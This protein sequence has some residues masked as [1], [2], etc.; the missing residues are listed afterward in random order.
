MLIALSSSGSRDESEKED[1]EAC[2]GRD[3]VSGFMFISSRGMRQWCVRDAFGSVRNAR[4]D[5][6]I[7]PLSPSRLSR[8]LS[9]V[10]LRRD[11]ESRDGDLRV[12]A[13]PPE[14]EGL[15]ERAGSVGIIHGVIREDNRR[16]AFHERVR[17]ERSRADSRGQRV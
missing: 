11:D 6:A 16:T 15:G 7:E 13:H 12:M 14:R 2:R 17:D 4:A 5:D 9:C 10:L 1:E 3:A 8:A